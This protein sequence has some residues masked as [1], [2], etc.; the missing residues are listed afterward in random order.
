[1]K[2]ALV[3]NETQCSDPWGGK[4]TG[5]NAEEFIQNLELW[6]EK[7]TGASINNIKRIPPRKD[8]IVCDACHCTSGYQLLI[9]PVPGSEQKFID[10]GFTK[11]Q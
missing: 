1:M 5:P 2:G 6:L 8:L 7:E 10:L 11:P 9:W 3:F 4:V